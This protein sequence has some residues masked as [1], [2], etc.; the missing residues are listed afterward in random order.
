MPPTRSG[1]TTAVL[2]CVMTAAGS[3]NLYVM[4]R[5]HSTQNCVHQLVGN[6]PSAVACGRGCGGA[7]GS[8]IAVFASGDAAYAAANAAARACRAST[9]DAPAS[10][11]SPAASSPPPASY[12]RSSSQS[13][14]FS[15]APQACPAA[16]KYGS[17]PA[18]GGPVVG[19]A[20]AT[21]P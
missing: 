16:A 4:V 10:A 6:A 5:R 20:S 15:S 17:T 13:P 9:A 14:G 12:N 18:A 21:G 2:A 3:R 19:A 1:S 11:S 8:A 7:S